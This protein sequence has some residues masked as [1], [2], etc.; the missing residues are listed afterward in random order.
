MLAL[1]SAATNLPAVIEPPVRVEAPQPPASEAVA[2]AIQTNSQAPDAGYTAT[3]EHRPVVYAAAE[4][5]FDP[6]GAGAAAARRGCL[7]VMTPLMLV[8]EARDEQVLVWGEADSVWDGLRRCHQEAERNNTV[9]RAVVTML[10]QAA[11]AAVAR[12]AGTSAQPIPVAP[13]MEAVSAGAM[14]GEQPGAPMPPAS[15]QPQIVVSPSA[16][17]AQPPMPPITA[18]AEAQIPLA[19][20]PPDMA[21][22]SVVVPPVT[23]PLVAPAEM[24][25]AAP[26]EDRPAA[27]SRRRERGR[28]APGTAM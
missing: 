8:V 9:L 3:G 15:P 12:P 4:L 25:G 20:N 26:I 24:S 7:E 27:G 22:P 14:A 13:A 5:S 17:A 11:A 1:Y 21:G 2:D 19:V 28:R 6:D 16:A 18:G 10:G 23:P